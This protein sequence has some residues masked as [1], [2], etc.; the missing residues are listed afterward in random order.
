MKV[1]LLR[2]ASQSAGSEGSE[3]VARET[4]TQALR[5]SAARPSEGVQFFDFG[6]RINSGQSDG[7]P[8]NQ[9][10]P[11]VSN[12]AHS[13]KTSAKLFQFYMQNQNHA[14]ATLA[15]LVSRALKNIRFGYSPRGLINQEPQ[16]GS[17]LFGGYRKRGKKNKK[18]KK[19]EKH[20]F[21]GHINPV[22]RLKI[23]PSQ[24]DPLKH[25][26]HSNAIAHQVGQCLVHASGCT[27]LSGQRLIPA[28]LSKVLMLNECLLMSQAVELV[29]RLSLIDHILAKSP[30]MRVK[31]F[32]SSSVLMC[33]T[34]WPKAICTSLANH[35]KSGAEYMYI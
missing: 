27:Q 1:G 23:A 33:S 21:R 29:D 17:V 24:G 6:E 28:F 10:I 14:L 2:L 5:K 19:G 4:E 35:H 22:D 26:M 18:E 3:L 7:T 20:N 13:E 30:A 8:R 9:Y 25:D 16:C 12:A 34:S 32:C 31:L 15:T 11:S